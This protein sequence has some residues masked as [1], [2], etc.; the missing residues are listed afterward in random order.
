M[1]LCTKSHFIKSL[2]RTLLGAEGPG[3]LDERRKI[4][5]E[6]S[7]RIKEYATNETGLLPGAVVLSWSES[8]STADTSSSSKAEY[9]RTMVDGIHPRQGQRIVYVDG[10]FDL[11]SSGHI[12]FLRQVVKAEE[13]L[14]RQ[15][16]WY[17]MSSIQARCAA[18]GGIDYGPAYI[19]AGVHDD[20]VINY[21]KGVNYPIMNI[22]ERGLCVL[23]CR[24][25]S[26]F[27]ISSLLLQT[28][29]KDMLM[30]PSTSTL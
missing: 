2:T 8:A 5:L 25:C 10:G 17:D 28:T 18:G 26:F 12:E 6:M 9:Y 7:Q 30:K 24:V 19:V 13:I 16:G 1:L 15:N 27:I 22:F 3:S 4:A 20:E 23:Q 29:T 11:F 14:G 21:W